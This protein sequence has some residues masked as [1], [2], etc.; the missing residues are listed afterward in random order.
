M[1]RQKFSINKMKITGKDFEYIKNNIIEKYKETFPEYL[2]EIEYKATKK[3]YAFIIYENKKIINEEG[4]IE[5]IKSY[6]FKYKNSVA[7]ELFAKD[8]KEEFYQKY[9]YD[10]KLDINE[11][12][13][14]IDSIITLYKLQNADLEWD[15]EKD[16]EFFTIYGPEPEFKSVFSHRPMK[17][18]YLR[19]SDCVTKKEF[20]KLKKEVI[21]SI[22]KML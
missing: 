8:K 1:G 16:N 7:I 3:N 17:L 10:Q 6:L 18:F 15:I 2:I 5:S 21:K 22:D 20:E 19:F 12:K 14:Y 9:Y 13:E 4:N 11:L